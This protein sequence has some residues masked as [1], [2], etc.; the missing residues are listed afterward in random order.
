MTTTG[1][2][3]RGDIEE[4]KGL[5]LDVMPKRFGPMALEVQWAIGLPV[6]QDFVPPPEWVKNVILDFCGISKVKPEQRTQLRSEYIS[7]LIGTSTGIADASMLYFEQ[8]KNSASSQAESDIL[9]RKFASRVD[10]PLKELVEKLE[11]AVSSLPPNSYKSTVKDLAVYTTA[12]SEAIAAV[13]CEDE[14]TIS[15]KLKYWLWVFWPQTATASSVPKL[16]QWIT[17]LGLIMCS[18]KLVEK[19]CREIGFRA[20]RMKPKKRI[21]TKRKKQ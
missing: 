19:I 18:D 11:T 12:R 14:G 6:P 2:N 8:E 4:T 17:G 9:I 15:Q 21:P 13:A 16:Y 5:L 1:D 20:T 10:A 3:K 7:S